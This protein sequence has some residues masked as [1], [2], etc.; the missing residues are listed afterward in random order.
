M[1]RAP[2]LSFPDASSATRLETMIYTL[3]TASAMAFSPQAGVPAGRT[4][5]RNQ[6][7]ISMMARTPLMAGNWKVG[8]CAAC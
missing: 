1:L 7:D 5:V 8:H 6:L 3:A 2:I 4:A